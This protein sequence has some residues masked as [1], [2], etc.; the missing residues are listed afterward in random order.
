M[1]FCFAVAFMTEILLALLSLFTMDRIDAF[2][3][4]YLI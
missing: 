4:K 2:L 1:T 3:K